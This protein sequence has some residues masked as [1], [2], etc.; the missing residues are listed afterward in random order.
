MV[1][2][3]TQL[4]RGAFFY[5]PLLPQNSIT[6]LATKR[7][8]LGPRTRKRARSVCVLATKS[9]DLEAGVFAFPAPE[10][11][12]PKMRTKSSAMKLVQMAIE[13]G[14]LTRTDQCE[15]CTKKPTD[16]KVPAIVGHHWNGYED[17]LN[18]WFVCR[19]CNRFLANKHDGSL[20]LTQAKLY[21]RQLQRAKLFRIH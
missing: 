13:S 9:T 18:V 21:V 7:Q 16:H 11:D 17:A 10:R 19:S 12:T 14:E 4:S 1:D 8:S 20:D 6:D 2:A 5:L 3:K 15:I